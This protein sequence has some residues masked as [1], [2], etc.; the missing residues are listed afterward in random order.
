MY[1]VGCTVY[2]A[3][4][5]KQLHIMK[6]FSSYKLSANSYWLFPANDQRRSTNDFRRREKRA[7]RFSQRWKMVQKV[8]EPKAPTLS[9]VGSKLKMRFLFDFFLFTFVSFPYSTTDAFKTISALA[10]AFLKRTSNCAASVFFPC[11]SNAW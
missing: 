9:V 3:L 5:Y 2:D 1:D 6:V 8:P 10:K 4:Y 11:N 7:L